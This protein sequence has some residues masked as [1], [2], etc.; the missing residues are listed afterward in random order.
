MYDGLLMAIIEFVIM[1]WV[2]LVRRG[3]KGKPVI[4]VEATHVR[5]R[6]AKL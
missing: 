5:V 4:I 6:F 3:I 2:V 1:F